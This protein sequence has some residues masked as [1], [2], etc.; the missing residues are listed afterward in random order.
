MQAGKD[1]VKRSDILKVLKKSMTAL[2]GAIDKEFEKDILLTSRV[3]NPET[4]PDSNNTQY[5][6]ASY[7]HAKP[8]PRN[9]PSK[10]FSDH[11]FTDR[12]A[13]TFPINST[14][15]T[16]N[17]DF[18]LT[19]YDY[20]NYGLANNTYDYAAIEASYDDR[21]KSTIGFSGNVTEAASNSTGY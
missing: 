10:T 3:R 18:N 21:S 14:R 16:A 17:P 11:I 7:D 20:S 13:R 4:N 1:G 15:F 19:N 2:N 12:A 9:L 8:A 5:D 6:Y